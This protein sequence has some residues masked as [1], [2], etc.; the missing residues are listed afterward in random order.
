MIMERSKMKDKKACITC[1]HHKEVYYYSYGL[2]IH[3]CFHPK[4]VY[5]Y[6]I[7]EKENENLGGLDC[8]QEREISHPSHCGPQAQFW[9]LKTKPEQKKS[10][11]DRVRRF[12]GYGF[13]RF[14]P[15]G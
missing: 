9:E 14:L 11:F 12:F 4:F 5:N 8:E 10:F 1:K 2:W 13:S 7:G 3:K 15:W 6:V